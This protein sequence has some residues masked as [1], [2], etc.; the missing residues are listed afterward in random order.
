MIRM[1]SAALVLGLS[2]CGA[3][4]ADVLYTIEELLPLPGQASGDSDLQTLSPPGR[5]GFV[6]AT[7]WGTRRASARAT[8]RLA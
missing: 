7:Q 6:P 3:A 2:L 4:L 5:P 8:D 1:L